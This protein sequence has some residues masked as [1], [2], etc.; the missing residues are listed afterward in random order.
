VGARRILIDSLADLSIAAG[1]PSRFR[2]WMYSLTHR[3]SRAGTSLMLTLEVPEL[4]A[5]ERVS[6]NGLSHLSDNVLLLQYLREE[7]RLQRTLT[8]LKTRASRHDPVVRPYEITAD[9]ITLV[10]GRGQRRPD[11]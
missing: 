11:R 10:N 1:D 9:G 4:F 8:V 2:E 6:E 7:D 5:M 3:F